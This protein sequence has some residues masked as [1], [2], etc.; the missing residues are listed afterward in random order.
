MEKVTLYT[1]IDVSK[2]THLRRNGPKK[3]DSGLSDKT[4]LL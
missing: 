1:G 3:L 2:L 4:A